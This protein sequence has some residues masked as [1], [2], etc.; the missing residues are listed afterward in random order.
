MAGH[1]YGSYAY[2]T[3]TLLRCQQNVTYRK[4]G[5]FLY[6]VEVIKGDETRTAVFKKTIKKGQSKSRWYSGKFTRILQPLE[7]IICF[8]NFMPMRTLE[9]KLS[10]ARINEQKASKTRKK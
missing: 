1:N 7:S 8:Q 9:L 10:N 3:V 5:L 4:F 6:Q 2:F